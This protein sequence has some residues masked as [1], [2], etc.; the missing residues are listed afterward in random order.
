M[1]SNVQAAFA[2]RICMLLGMIAVSVFVLGPAVAM[3]GSRHRGHSHRHHHGHRGHHHHHHRGHHGLRFSFGGHRHHFGFGRGFYHRGFRH[4]GYYPRLFGYSYIP[5][6]Y[7]YS[8]PRRHLYSYGYAIPRV[9][10]YSGSHCGSRLGYDSAPQAPMPDYDNYEMDDYDIDSEKGD[11]LE[12]AKSSEA[13]D[14]YTQLR[15]RGWM[16]LAEDQPSAAL[17][18]FARDAQ[19]NLSNGVHKV[20]YSISAAATGRLSRGVW[21]MRRACRIDPDSMH[22]LNIEQIDHRIPAT[23]ERLEEAYSERIA[24]RR[25]D[26]DSAFMVAS[27]RYLIGKDTQAKD[28]I[29]LAVRHGDRASSTSNLQHAI[30]TRLASHQ[31]PNPQLTDSSNGE[32]VDTAVPLPPPPE[33]QDKRTPARVA[34]E[35]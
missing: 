2:R 26:R 21:A 24:R 30:D 4:R 34:V 7:A 33:V 22:H 14:E 20:G 17:R 13:K 35:R 32:K 25:N 27:L 31:L 29:D 28:A 5:R 6:L 9:Y 1:P 10:G 23:V 15:S 12:G 8:Y 11:K 3:A 19:Q 16:L 18:E